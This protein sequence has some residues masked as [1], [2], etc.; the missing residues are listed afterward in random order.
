MGM[1]QFMSLVRVRLAQELIVQFLYLSVL[2]G[3]AQ[4]L[5]LVLGVQ[6]LGALCPE[7]I[8]NIV[9]LMGQEAGPEQLEV[10]V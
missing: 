6:S 5:A 1:Q 7:G 2:M 8:L 9:I 4:L 10:I 3:L